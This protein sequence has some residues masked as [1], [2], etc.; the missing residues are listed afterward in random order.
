DAAPPSFAQTGQPYYPTIVAAFVCLLLVS[1]IAATKG[2]QFGPFIMD[3]GAFLFP[4]TYV[5]GDALAEVYGFRA[6]RRAIVLGFAATLVASLTFWLVMISPGAPG[7]ENQAAFEAVLGVV[8]RILLAS[9]LGYLAGQLLNALTLVRIKARTRERHLWARLIGSTLVGEAADTL[10]FCA[11]A[12][13]AIGIQTM[14]QFWNYVAVGYVYKVAV[15]VLVLPVTY[16]LVAF[17][18]RREPSYGS[19]TT[20]SPT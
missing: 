11:I 20:A 9:L 2:I 8:P 1:N 6:T 7:Y 14:G 5:L 15:E 4:L 12:A 10:V 18:K 19:P 17:L 3:G 13:G 16:R